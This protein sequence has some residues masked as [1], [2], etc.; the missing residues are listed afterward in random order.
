MK[1]K[2]GWD[3]HRDG[4]PGMAHPCT[5][6]DYETAKRMHERGNRGVEITEAFRL[7]CL[8]YEDKIASLEREL[9]GVYRQI[10]QGG[11]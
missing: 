3:C 7:E 5:R 9:L 10:R 8:R 1:K 4:C 2:I 11:G 6:V